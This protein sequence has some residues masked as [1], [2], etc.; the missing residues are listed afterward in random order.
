[1]HVGATLL[2]RDATIELEQTGQKASDSN[3]G[4]A[5]LLNFSA[6]WAFANMAF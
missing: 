3:V 1:M 5:P 6:E 2:V 4:V